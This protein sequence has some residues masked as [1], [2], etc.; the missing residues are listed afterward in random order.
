MGVTVPAC[1]TCSGIGSVRSKVK[2]TVKIPP[3]VYTGLVL[4]S[5]GKGNQMRPGTGQAGD[6]LLKITVEEHPYF[7]REAENVLSE[8]RIPFTKAVFGGKVKIRTLKGLRD[9]EIYPGTQDGQETV[10]KG[11]GM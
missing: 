7:K 3:G 11:A 5:Q 10:I 8:E 6:L 9:V 2:E 4:R 1:L